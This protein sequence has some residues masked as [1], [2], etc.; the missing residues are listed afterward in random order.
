MNGPI[1]SVL[2]AMTVVLASFAVAHDERLEAS[3]DATRANR[4]KVGLAKWPG[5]QPRNSSAQRM[6]GG[7]LSP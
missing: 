3:D 7:T 6:D 1:E 2:A 5:G 4:C